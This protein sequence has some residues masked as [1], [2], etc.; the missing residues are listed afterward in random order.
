MKKEFL[1]VEIQQNLNRIIITGNINCMEDCF[2]IKKEIELILPKEKFL[3]VE[4][5]DSLF[6]TASFIGYL[7]KLINV[8]NVYIELKIGRSELFDILLDKKIVEL[9]NAT[10]INN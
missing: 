7:L 6:I 8:D 9:F 4:L 5:R 1:M 3:V 10:L 2:K